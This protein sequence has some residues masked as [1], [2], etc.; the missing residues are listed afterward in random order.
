[1]QKIKKQQNNQGLLTLSDLCKFTEEV[2]LPSVKTM[3]K[4]EI[5]TEIGKH[6]HDM[7]NYIDS[8]LSDTKGDIISYIKGDRERDQSWKMKI[9][10]ILKREKLAKPVELKILADLIR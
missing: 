1:M 5:K 6:R 9:V 3:V 8:K 7:K 4:E 2:L 10:N